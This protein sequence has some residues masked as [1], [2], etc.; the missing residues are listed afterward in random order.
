MLVFVVVRCGSLVFW[1]L[2]VCCLLCVY[3]LLLVVSRVLG[4]NIVRGSSCVARR[5][6]FVVCCGVF[7]DCYVWFYVVL[8]CVLCIVC[9]VLYV[10]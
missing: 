10:V 4:L 7:V 8:C 9:L 5:V 2:V 6:L 3:L 1:F